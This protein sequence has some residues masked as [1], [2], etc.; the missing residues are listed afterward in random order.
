MKPSRKLVNEAKGYAKYSNHE[1]V[2]V[3]AVIYRK[4]RPLG[5]G[6]NYGAKTHPKSPH[7]YRS[8]HAEFSALLDYV[9][10]NGVQQVSKGLSIYVHR[11][12]LDGSDG[13]AKPCQWCQKMLDSVG[14]SEIY[15][16]VG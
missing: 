13:L 11:L 14:I 8:T 16:S 12:K 6:F 9:G 1:R 15:W 10:T 4:D 5:R 3:G 7:P 2:R